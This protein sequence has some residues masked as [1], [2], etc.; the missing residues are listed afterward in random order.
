MSRTLELTKSGWSSEINRVRGL[1]AHVRARVWGAVAH[2]MGQGGAPR[3][4]AHDFGLVRDEVHAVVLE[5]AG[6]HR[7]A[8]KGGRLVLERSFR[9]MMTRITG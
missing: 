2:A 9:P 5:E 8:L 7:L 6:V 4:T 1:S 3:A